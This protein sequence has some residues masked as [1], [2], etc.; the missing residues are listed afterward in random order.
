MLNKPKLVIDNNLLLFLMVYYN[1]KD[2]HSQPRLQM[3]RELFTN[4]VNNYYLIFPNKNIM[5]STHSFT[6]TPWS[7]TTLGIPKRLQYQLAI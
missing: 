7:S 5:E 3:F 1:G 6:C 2:I 4:L